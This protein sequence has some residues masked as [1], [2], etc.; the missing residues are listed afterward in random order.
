MEAE[1]LK[2]INMGQWDGLTFS[3]IKE[4][5]PRE[6]ELRGLDFGSFVPQVGVPAAMLRTR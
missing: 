6:Y 2:E 1:E 4:K 3:E 5:Y